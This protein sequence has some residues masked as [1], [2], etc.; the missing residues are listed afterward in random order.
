MPRAHLSQLDP[1]IQRA[2]QDVAHELAEDGALSVLVTGSHVRHAGERES[3]LDIVALYRT[4]RSD[5]WKARHAITSYGGT[6]V[7]VV[8]ETPRGAYGSF[9]DPGLIPTSV[10]GWRMGI[11]LHDTD[12]IANELQREATAFSWSA[13]ARECDA[14]VAMQVVGWAEE[15]HKV[16]AALRLGKQY[17]AAGNRALLALHLAGVLGVHRRILL[18]TENELWGLVAREM[19][20]AW[21]SAQQSAL[22]LNGE[23]LEESSRAA[24]RLYVIAADETE[25]VLN[26]RQRDVVERACE[27]ARSQFGT[28]VES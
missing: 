12:D 1:Y 20:A 22:S 6:M 9:R 28:A 5:A 27:L 16:A 18:E 14:W 3:D 8:A 17:Q 15:A 23:S 21:A 25:R 7:V 26:P 24:L 11:I 2:A 13:V 4:K 10:P 19:G